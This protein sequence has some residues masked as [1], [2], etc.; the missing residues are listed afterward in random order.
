MPVYKNEKRNTWY[1]SFYYKDWT[2]KRIRKKKEGFATRKQAADFERE[3]IEISEGQCTMRFSSLVKIYM[4]DSKKRIKYST[5]VTRRSIISKHILPFFAKM[6]INCI[7]PT[8]V[9]RWQNWILT[10][11]AEKS[12]QYLHKLNLQ[13]STIFRFA[14][15]F[16]K[17]NKNP[18]KACAMLGSTKRK[19]LSFWT[20]GE[21]K[22][23]IKAIDGQE[24]L[25][26]ISNVL[27][28]SGVRRGELLALRPS[29]FDF[30]KNSLSVSRNV[31]F[32]NSRA[33]LS[34]LKTDRSERQINIPDF[35]ADMVKKYIQTQDIRDN[36]FLFYYL[37][38]YL[39]EKIRLYSI[40][41]GL[42]PIKIHGFRHS[43]ASLLIEQGISPLLI[44]QRLGHK[45]VTTTLKYYAHLYPNKQK[46]LA[47]KLHNLYK[48]NID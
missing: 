5:Y 7:T 21:F 45:D 33:Y 39:M 32:I 37:P 23:F 11:N 9:N 40:K 22:R 16:Y 43:H 15:K 27:F 3:F 24:P 25:H 14:E 19:N 17:L 34:S 2:G 30:E 1:A 41:A 38:S 4:D 13:L 6:A 48:E 36:E 31:V 28:W 44:A 29:D 12:P 8:D 26:T 10:H 18:A 35:L 46:K 47:K 42:K 20:L